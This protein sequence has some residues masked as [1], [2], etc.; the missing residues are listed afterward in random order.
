MAAHRAGN[1]TLVCAILLELLVD[2]AL[3]K[4]LITDTD[5]MGKQLHTLCWQPLTYKTWPFGKNK[6]KLLSEIPN[7]YYLWAL[8][9]IDALNESKDGYDYD[10]AESV[11][12]E[13]E[14]RLQAPAGE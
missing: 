9:N 4:G 3:A 1:D 12:M 14:K 5:S 10:L 8:D 6:G 13:L 11:R 2:Y 7:D